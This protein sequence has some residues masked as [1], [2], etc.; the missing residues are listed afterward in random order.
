[1]FATIAA[2]MGTD[3]PD[4]EQSI[5]FGVDLLGKTFQKGRTERTETMKAV[6]I[7]IVEPWAFKPQETNFSIP[8][9]KKMSTDKAKQQKMDQN[10]R[11]YI[12]HSQSPFCMRVYAASHFQPKPKLIGFRWSCTP[13]KDDSPEEHINVSVMWEVVEQKIRC[14]NCRSLSRNS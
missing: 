9:T 6:M 3:I 11:E 5:I 4:I 13:D 10:A 2:G 14:G 8:S 7:W 1:V 12:N